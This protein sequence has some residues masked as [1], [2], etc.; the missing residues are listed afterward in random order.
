MFE[1]NLRIWTIRHIRDLPKDI[2]QEQVAKT[3]IKRFLLSK[4]CSSYIKHIVN[5]LRK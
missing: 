4:N 1:E 5:K 2:S 3:I